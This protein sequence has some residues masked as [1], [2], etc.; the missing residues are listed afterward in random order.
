MRLF[1]L[2]LLSLFLCSLFS[3]GY[4]TGSL[5]PSQY[6]TIGVQ[7]FKNSINF[8]SEGTRATYVPLLENKVRQAILDRFQYDGHLRLGDAERSDLIMSGELIEFKREELRL[9]DDRD[10]QEYRIRVV[11]SLT[12]TD[13]TNGEVLWL[14]PQFGGEATYFTSGPRAISESAALE[15]AL[16]DLSRRIVERTLE[17]W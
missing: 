7:N 8:V 11:V 4:T 17:N 16:T 9:T 10:V 15:E 14:E 5:L 6:R 3:C 12:L 1:R 13:G 2:S